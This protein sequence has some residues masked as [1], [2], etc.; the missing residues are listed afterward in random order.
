MP[1]GYSFTHEEQTGEHGGLYWE[2]TEQPDGTRVRRYFPNY[3]NRFAKKFCFSPDPTAI[4]NLGP[5][6]KQLGR[7]EEAAVFLFESQFL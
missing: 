2:D 7:S 5:L 6:L 4:R 3:L 1:T